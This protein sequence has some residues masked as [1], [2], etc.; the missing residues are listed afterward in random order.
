LAKS[1]N[2]LDTFPLCRVEVEHSRSTPRR[3]R[4]EAKGP[5]VLSVT[6]S[7]L[8]LVAAAAGQELPKGSQKA[9]I[10]SGFARATPGS[11]ATLLLSRGLDTGKVM[12]VTSA[13]VNNHE[14]VLRAALADGNL[15]D[16]DAGGTTPKQRC[17][18]FNPGV[19]FGP[20]EMFECKVL[21]GTND[22]TCIL[23]GYQLRVT[24]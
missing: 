7:L 12:V 5:A 4:H 23:S 22:A 8:A 18:S 17:I 2:F 24:P 11:P 1:Q 6:L 9:W 16:Q 21:S 10:V 3:F 20:A 15:A 19:V 14:A 13:C